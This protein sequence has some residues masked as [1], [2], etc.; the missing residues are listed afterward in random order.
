[1]VA[2]CRPAPGLSPLGSSGSAHTC[3]ALLI[4]V[5]SHF[6][7]SLVLPSWDA[8]LSFPIFVF[9]VVL[10]DPHTP[11]IP[12]EGL[13]WRVGANRRGGGAWE[14]V[15]HLRLWGPFWPGRE[16]IGYWLPA[17]LLGRQLTIVLPNVA[18]TVSSFYLYIYI[19]IF[20]FLAVLCS[21]Q[22]PS[23]PTGD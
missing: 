3:P 21:I 19:C 4:C 11:S 1:M 12:P 22:D 23:F 8:L 6:C 20:Y 10:R 13:S 18:F 5:A 7:D 16:M 14:S 17:G 9:I 2:G 15:F